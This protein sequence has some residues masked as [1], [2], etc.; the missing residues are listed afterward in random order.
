VVK[1]LEWN[2]NEGVGITD[3][4]ARR[5][6]RPGKDPDEPPTARRSPSAIESSPS[7]T[8]GLGVVRVDLNGSNAQV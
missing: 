2:G 5:S 8:A 4:V 7:T 1:P 3:W 6:S